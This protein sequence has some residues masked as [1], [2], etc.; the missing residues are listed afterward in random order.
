MANGLC[1]GHFPLAKPVIGGPPNGPPSS[2]QRAK[3][4]AKTE[5]EYEPAQEPATPGGYDMVGPDD[6][7][8]NQLNNSHLFCSLQCSGLGKGQFNT[9]LFW[10]KST[11][12]SI[13]YSSAASTELAQWLAKIILYATVAMPST[14]L[15]LS[16]KQL[17]EAPSSIG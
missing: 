5:G 6:F 7:A 12:S 1:L 16:K 17:S 10:H 3:E 15:F 8:G 9:K 11:L 14:R 13:N 4:P 2:T